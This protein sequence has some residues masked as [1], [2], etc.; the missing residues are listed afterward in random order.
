MPGRTD[1][2]RRGFILVMT[3]MLIAIAAVALVSVGRSSM[4]LAVNA[5]QARQDLQRRWGSISCRHTLLRLAPVVLETAATDPTQSRNSV[6]TQIQLNN[7]TYTLT[8][9]DEQAKVNIN[10]MLHIHGR[11]AARTYIREQCGS[12]PWSDKIVLPTTH[13]QPNPA[14]ISEADDSHRKIISI[15]HVL[16]AY[17]PGY[18]DQDGCAPLDTITCW[19]DG[20]IN[21]TRATDDLVQ[22]VLK[23]MLSTAE[24][25]KL[26]ESISRSKS[27]SLVEAIKSLGVSE[28]DMP[29]LL[30][31][32]TL[33]SSC[34]SVWIVVDNHMR[35]WYELAV[36]ELSPGITTELQVTGSQ[37]SA[38]AAGAPDSVVPDS[39]RRIASRTL[40]D[41]NAQQDT[42]EGNVAP[43]DDTYTYP[44]L[45]LYQW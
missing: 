30:N 3:L 12:H 45:Y 33:D 29:P 26:R 19:G 37:K 20:R 15:N 10:T 36:V 1:T 2:S 35:S 8:L 4:R 42:R 16:P 38:G 44:R 40:S 9:S 18:I 27:E 13:T 25:R 31:R 5:V 32:L 28:D 7:T 11:E 21:L 22:M 24:I 39:I 14:G 23:P 41:E 17:D 43:A 34:Y 6:Q